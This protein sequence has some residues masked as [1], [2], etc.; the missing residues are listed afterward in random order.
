M[1]KTLI[2]ELRKKHGWTQEHLAS[3]CGLS[4]RT[5][6]RLEKGDD[7]SLESLR[8][9][10]Q[11]LNVKVGDLF[12]SV[13]DTQKGRD[14][15]EINSN[16]NNQIRKRKDEFDLINKTIRM[17]FILLM[18]IFACIMSRSQYVSILGMIWAFSWIIGFYILRLIKIY[19]L[20]SYLDKKYPLTKNLN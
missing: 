18:I 3:K 11:A 5:I 15:M 12:E 10:A 13:S 19:W 17:T 8:L 6:Q 1:N 16:Q 2:P 20:E 9:V 7:A 14:I 4:V